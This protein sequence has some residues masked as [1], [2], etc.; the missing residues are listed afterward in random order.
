MVNPSTVH[1]DISPR[2]FR[3]LV[4]Q[5]APQSIL[6]VGHQRSLELSGATG[7]L[8]GLSGF[9]CANF[10]EYKPN[11]TL[12]EVRQGLELVNAVKPDLII[13][14]GGGSAIDVAKMLTVCGSPAAFNMNDVLACGKA[15]HRES[16][17]RLIAIPT[18][19]GTG[20][21]ATHF[22]TIYHAGKK[23]SI[24]SPQMIPDH[25]I[26]NAQLT[27]SMPPYVAGCTG[28]D[29]LAHGIESYW[30]VSSTEESSRNSTEAITR[31]LKYL[32]IVAQ[33]DSLDARREV[34]LGA[35]YAGR[36]INLTKTTAPHAV[37]YALTSRLGL[38]HGHA[39]FLTL[40]W[41]LEF[42]NDVT[43]ESLADKRG[44]AHVKERMQNIF[45]MLG[46]DSAATARESAIAFAESV[47]VKLVP[48]PVQV[49]A[50]P[51]IPELAK[52][53]DLTRA[54]NNPRVCTVEEVSA[55][56]ARL[57]R[58]SS[59][60]SVEQG[61]RSNGAEEKPKGTIY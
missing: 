29:A 23:Y 7:L 6:T 27:A 26:L 48:L 4:H 43:W 22:A 1:Y 42:N 49:D 19:A 11:P 30:S 44:I 53:F 15:P 17:P 52:V 47:G 39:V 40:P 38:A 14:V 57:L 5:L 3:E 37:S 36:A 16:K 33:T 25:V 54:G 13:A 34:L 50:E 12:D 41:F 60:S 31:L 35:H 24:S 56:L 18:T 45:Q 32:P 20:S 46:C 9:L 28:L 8:E 58:P 51:M 55:M 61:S 2:H 21:E 59:N 10:S